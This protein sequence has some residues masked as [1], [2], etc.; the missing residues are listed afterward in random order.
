MAEAREI[1]TIEEAIED[2]RRG[3]M[4]ILVDDEERENEGDLT[5]AAEKV[6]PEAINFMATHGRGLIC[7][8]LTDEKIKALDLPMMTYRNESR[9]GTGFTVSIDAREGVTTGISAFD[10]ARTVL[11]AIRPDAKPEDLVRPGHIFPLRAVRGGVLR[12]A[13]QTEGSVDLARLAGLYPAAVICEVMNDDGTMARL[14]HL[15]EFGKRFGIKIVTIADLIKYRLKKDRLIEKIGKTKLPTEFGDFD[16]SIYK[17]MVDGSTHLALTMGE[18]WTD[19]PVIIRVQ[20]Q[21]LIGHVFRSLKCKCGA[22]LVNAM[23]RIAEEGKGAVIYLE[24][25]GKGF[26]DCYGIEAEQGDEQDKSYYPVDLRD[27]GLGAQILL[28]LGIRKLRIMTNNPKKIIGLKG[29]GIEIV[30]WV[31]LSVGGEGEGCVLEIGSRTVLK[32][33]GTDVI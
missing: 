11:T 30:E 17:D 14:P 2:M 22:Q 15:V 31:P 29:Y 20:S 26:A 13:G 3:K 28:D 23:K 19:E 25:E 10:R 7:L 18:I 6:T 4:V 5:I 27:Y 32:Q 33:A 12:R 21:C 16:L 24:R 1:S 8:A 9:F